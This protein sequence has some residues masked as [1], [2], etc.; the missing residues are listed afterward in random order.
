MSSDRFN[1][2]YNI[3]V[4]CYRKHGIFFFFFFFRAAGAAYR[5]YQGRGRIGA[6]AASHAMLDPYP[7][8]RR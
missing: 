3:Q 2:C 7:T 8:E 4:L 1:S 6:I 5:S